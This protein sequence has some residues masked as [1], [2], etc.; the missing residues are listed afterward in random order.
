MC[1]VLISW[2]RCRDTSPEIQLRPDRHA[3]TGRG[4]LVLRYFGQSQDA[5]EDNDDTDD[6][7]DDDDTEVADGW[8]I[9]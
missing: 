8:V 3:G 7:D 2:R 9:R 1:N 6:G 4:K 5:T